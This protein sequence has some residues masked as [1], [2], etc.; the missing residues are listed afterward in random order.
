MINVRFFQRAGLS[1][2]QSNC[3]VTQY[4]LQVTHFHE[5]IGSDNE[6]QFIFMGIF[7]FN[8][9]IVKNAGIKVQLLQ[10]PTSLAL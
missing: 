9:S 6:F 5:N 10:L 1:S 2:N 4:A 3:R 7:K 8:F